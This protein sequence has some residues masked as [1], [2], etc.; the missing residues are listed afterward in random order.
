[1][2]T[3]LF[4][5]T[6]KSGKKLSLPRFKNIPVG[7]IR[8]NRKEDEDEQTFGLIEAVADAKTLKVIDSMSIVELGEFMQAWQKDSGV[9]M[10]ESSAS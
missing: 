2:A 5:H 8:K 7:V 9:E 3:E 10:G 1:M 6:T 4:H